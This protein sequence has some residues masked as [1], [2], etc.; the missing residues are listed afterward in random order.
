MAR[1]KCKTCK[2]DGRLH[3]DPCPF[4]PNSTVMAGPFDCSCGYPDCSACGGT[5]Q[6][7]RHREFVESVIEN[8]GIPK[9]FLYPP[10]KKK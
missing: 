5:G 6:R 1:K 9:E 7:Q 2:G 3:L 8:C 10:D 4:G